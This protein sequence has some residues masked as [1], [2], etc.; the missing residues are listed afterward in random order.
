MTTPVRVCVGVDLDIT[1]SGAVERH[2]QQTHLART[3]RLPDQTD[4]LV[5]AVVQLV[6]WAVGDIDGATV[7]TI[8]GGRPVYRGAGT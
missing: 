3:G 8:E 1:D 5:D 4:G 7:A 6:E 2:Y